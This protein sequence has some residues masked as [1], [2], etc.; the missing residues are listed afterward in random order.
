MIFLTTGENIRKFRTEL[1]LTQKELGKAIGTTQQMI[2]QYEN[3]QRNPKIETLNKIA[4]ALHTTIEELSNHTRSFYEFN[5]PT[6]ELLNMYLDE[7]DFEE[8]QRMQAYYNI[9]NHEGKQEA[10]KRVSE[11]TEIKKYTEP[12]T[13]PEPDQ[14]PDANKP[15]TW[16][17]KITD[18]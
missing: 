4:K 14:E 16:K 9:L 18:F 12:D 3:G 11:L 8:Q 10:I 2:A 17:V 1:K 5:I 7:K 6:T 15:D 13:P